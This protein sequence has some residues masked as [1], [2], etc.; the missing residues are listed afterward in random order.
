MNAVV[1]QDNPFG[2]PTIAAKQS[3]ALVAVEQSRAIAEI[4]AAMTIAK[5]FPRDPIVAMDKILNACTRP[6]L[7]EQALY[8]Y[9]RGGTEIAGP[10]IRLAEALAQA[11][12]NIKTSVRELEQRDGMSTV[13]AI[14]WDLESGY[15]S[16]KVFQVKHWRDK[17]DG[18]GYVIT[19]ARDIYEMVANQGARRLRACILAVIPGDVVEAAARQCEATLHTKA[20]VTADSLAAMVEAFGEF[21]VSKEQIEKRIQRRLDAMT[22]G[23]L[24]SLR[25]IYNSLRDGMSGPAE[26]FEVVAPPEGQPPTSGAAKIKEAAARVKGRH[27]EPQQQKEPPASSGASGV[28]EPI[29]DEAKALLAMDGAKDEGEAAAVLDLCRGQPF[30]DGIV[31]SY[32]ERFSKE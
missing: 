18:K 17:K 16:D 28:P 7:A 10:S 31:A 24:V 22:P 23:Q 1:K 14:A 11:W 21:G 15:Q 4:Q 20:E 6:T 13:Q 32:K 29:T 12:G 25:K 8:T 26:W 19:D 3:E 9:S 2:S 30:Y 27:A 5:S